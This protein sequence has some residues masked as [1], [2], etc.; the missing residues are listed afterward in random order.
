MK[1]HFQPSAE[2]VNQVF[3]K[4]GFKKAGMFGAFRFFQSNFVR[5][6]VP[7][8]LTTLL[9]VFSYNYFFEDDKNSL[10]SNELLTNNKQVSNQ[11]KR[12]I[13]KENPLSK[14]N[15]V[16]NNIKPSTNDQEGLKVLK[17]LTATTLSQKDN[18]VTRV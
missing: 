15:V 3:T 13:S 10:T 9:L 5:F 17:V 4:L 2:S 6:S 12:K 14:E 18:K 7:A 1:I 8:V 16:E 11:T